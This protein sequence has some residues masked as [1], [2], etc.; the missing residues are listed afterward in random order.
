MADRCRTRPGVGMMNFRVGI[1]GAGRMGK[2]RSRA[3]QLLGG[4]ITA[5]CDVD[6]E[7]AIQLAKPCRALATDRTEDLDIPSLDALFVCTPPALR[8][9]VETALRAQVPVFVEKPLALSADHCVPLLEALRR[10]ET[11][12]AVG[13]MNRY[14]ATVSMAQERIARNTP[15]GVSFQWF[16]SR[17]RVPW[18]LDPAQSGGP[19]NEQCTHYIDMCRFLI[20][21]ISEV[22]AFVRYLPDVAEVEGSAAITLRFENGLLGTG[23]YSCEA[24]QKQMTFEVFL[25]DKSVRLEGWALSLPGHSGDEDIFLRETKA[26]FDAILSGDRSKVLSDFDS[27]MRTQCVIDAIRRSIRSGNRE[28]VLQPEEVAVY[29]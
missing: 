11:I 8:D 17:Y 5:V 15:V 27:A 1:I 7:R 6:L 4:N 16:A 19:I 24:S 25:P 21:E 9:P 14:R 2:E 3:V 20:G 28:R 23:L 26:F 12:N 22:H 29:T 10:H 13:Y 18:W